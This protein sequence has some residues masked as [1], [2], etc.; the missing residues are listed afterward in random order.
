M[1]D[2]T[3]VV[4]VEPMVGAGVSPQSNPEEFATVTPAALDRVR[5]LIEQVAERLAA[6]VFQDT[7]SPEELTVEFGIGLKGDARIPFLAKAGVEANFKVTAKW[8][9]R[10]GK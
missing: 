1:S 5:E 4:Q 7:L 6:T 8:H 10:E 2:L 9:R 3:F